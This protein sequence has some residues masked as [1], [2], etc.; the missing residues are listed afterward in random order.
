MLSNAKL[1]D[2]SQSLNTIAENT[3]GF[4]V[5]VSQDD[6]GT[7][8]FLM[9]D[10]KAEVTVSDWTAVP[11]GVLNGMV[12][13]YYFNS[14]EEDDDEGVMGTLEPKMVCGLLGL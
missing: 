13:V 10:P 14:S 6:D 3:W 12:P 7:I 9:S 8:S 5:D 1:V 11:V 2:L 4:I